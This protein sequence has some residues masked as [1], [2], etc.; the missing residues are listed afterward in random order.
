MNYSRIL[1]RAVIGG[2]VGL[3]VV[4]DHMKVAEAREQTCLTVFKNYASV[5]EEGGEV[6]YMTVDDF[7]RSLLRKRNIEALPA[8]A[9]DDIAALFK[10]VDSNSDGLLSFQEYSLFM[11]LLTNSRH[12]IEQCFRM[13]DFDQS[14]TIEMEEFKSMVIALSNDPTVQYTWEGG[15]TEKFFKNKKSLTFNEF[16]RFV[17]ELKLQVMKAEFHAFNATETGT[18]ESLTRL[19]F[20]PYLP[21]E[22]APNR[23][24]IQS[25]DRRGRTIHLRNWVTFNELFLAADDLQE[26]F[27]VYKRSGQAIKKQDFIR[28]TTASAPHINLTRREVEAIFLIFGRPDGTLNDKDFIQTMLN[29]RSWGLQT[30]DRAEPRRNFAQTFLNCVTTGN[31]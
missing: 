29:K 20:G 17:E 9:T 1:R 8:K 3:W 23:D 2:G 22:I 7:V 19:L 18:V 27:D 12:D 30:T 26:A 31:A 15:L 6:L 10:D 25:H 16:Y 4:K 14:N 24:R 28:A 5:V 13:F 11:T 21:P